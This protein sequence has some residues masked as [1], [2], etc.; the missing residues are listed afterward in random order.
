V[1]RHDEFVKVMNSCKKVFHAWDDESERFR[2]LLRDQLKSRRDNTVKTL[3]KM[4]SEHDLLQER[5]KALREL[6]RC[7]ALIAAGCAILTA[8]WAMRRQ[9]SF[10]NSTNSCR[11]SSNASSA[12]QPARATTALSRRTGLP[13][14]RSTTPT[15]KPPKQ[16]LWTSPMLERACG[17]TPWPPIGSASRRWVIVSG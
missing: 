16:T 1:Y 6:L 7:R 5:I 4:V 10:A 11:P 3:R 2:T 17:T 9:E 12:R 15:Q 14:P 8:S 13:S